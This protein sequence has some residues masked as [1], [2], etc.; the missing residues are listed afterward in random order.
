M[1][2]FV[3]P[4][5][6]RYRVAYRNSACRRISRMFPASLY[7]RGPWVDGANM[8]MEPV[9]EEAY[10]RAMGFRSMFGRG[11]GGLCMIGHSR[12]GAAVIA[13]ARTG[14]WTASPAT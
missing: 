13:G 10:W 7:P 8:N 12:G 4:N 1:H 11:C 5:D 3:A 14:T 9:I 2:G 6:D